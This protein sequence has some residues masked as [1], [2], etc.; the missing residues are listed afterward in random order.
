MKGLSLSVPVPTLTLYT[1]ASNLGWGA[2]LE[3]SC[4]L[5]LWS[6]LQQK[7]HINL[8]EMK[9][10]H[11]ALSHFRATLHFKSLVLATDN[12][13]VVAYLKHQEALIVSTCILFAGRFSFFARNFRFNW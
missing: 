6:P 2:Y 4:A 12:T 8:L 5:G 9:A 13:T 3:G 1:D 10:V 11:L 7:E